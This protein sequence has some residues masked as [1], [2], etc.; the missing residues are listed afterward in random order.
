[1]IFFFLVCYYSV[2]FRDFETLPQGQIRKELYIAS[3]RF[4]EF[5]FTGRVTN[6]T[7]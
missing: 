1:M 2:P 6:I 5:H 7:L 4:L 3:H